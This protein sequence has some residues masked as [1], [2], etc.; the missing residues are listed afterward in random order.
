MT[1]CAPKNVKA[2]ELMKDAA[3][4]PGKL[5]C[6]FASHRPCMGEGPTAVKAA[7]SECFVNLIIKESDNNVKLIILDHMG[8][9]HFKHGHTLDG[10][11]MFL[12][13][14]DMEVRRKPMSIILSMLHDLES[15][16]RG[17]CSLPE[18]APAVDTGARVREARS[19]G[20]F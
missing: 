13:S 2:G 8:T 11:T 3:L 5:E 1:T 12:L 7:A 9:L 4:S 20:N 16:R 17:S 14:A 15:E 18:E 19:T 6:V 10:P